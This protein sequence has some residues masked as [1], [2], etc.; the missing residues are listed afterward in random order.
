MALRVLLADNSESIRKVIQLSLQDFAV[1]VK[2]VA[3][4]VDVLEIAKGFKPDVIFV[5]ILLQKKNGYEV[6]YELKSNPELTMV[7]IILMWSNFMEI[8]AAKLAACKAND[9]IEKPFDSETIRALVRKWVPKAKTS[10]L[11]QHL[12]MPKAGLPTA[13][14]APQAK[15]QPPAQAQPATA[16]PQA[17]APSGLPT[18]PPVPPAK[19]QAPAAPPPLPAVEA[20]VERRSHA[21]TAP[22]AAATPPAFVP[23]FQSLPGQ[24]SEL[25]AEEAAA[26]APDWSMDSFEDIQKYESPEMPQLPADELPEIVTP[27]EMEREMLKS[28]APEALPDLELE[29]PDEADDFQIHSVQ[30][31]VPKGAEDPLQ[32]LAKGPHALEIHETP[33]ELDLD[34]SH[35]GID[36]PPPE[37]SRVPVGSAA[38]TQDSTNFGSAE[39]EQ[40]EWVQSSADRFAV[41]LPQENTQIEIGSSGDESVQA[42]DFVYAPLDATANEVAASVKT[43]A[44]SIGAR[45]NNTNVSSDVV[46]QLVQAQIEKLLPAAVNKAASEIIQRWVEQNLPDYAVQSIQAELD[47]LMSDNP[48]AGP[49]R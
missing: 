29:L 34:L 20:A 8:D 41:D 23:P 19:V 13:P 49:R 46:D 14:P 39:D 22:A 45:S 32:K 36:L 25:P 7:P 33:R 28:R 5:D 38:T 15:A 9:K 26:G 3:L 2:T 47:R 48:N 30:A 43:Q 24:G 4:G 31:D 11:A 27:A 37:E 42:D 35:V 1:E 10:P 21:T 12:V 16:A 17:T 40:Q 44:T 6:S 18:A